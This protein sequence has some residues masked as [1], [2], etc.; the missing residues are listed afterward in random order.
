MCVSSEKRGG[1]K[2]EK[3]TFLGGPTVAS[4]R[5]MTRQI[6]N[7]SRESVLL[8]PP[9]W[10]LLT[11]SSA[12]HITVNCTCEKVKFVL[13][14]LSLISHNQWKTFLLE[15]YSI[16]LQP[17]KDCQS[18]K[19]SFRVPAA[20]SLPLRLSPVS[21]FVCV[22]IGGSTVMILPCKGKT[23]PWILRL[24]SCDV[25]GIPAVTLHWNAVI[26]LF[27]WALFPSACLICFR[28]S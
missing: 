18:W 10:E 7:Q 12:L 14:L 3:E 24:W 22:F 13:L 23:H 1:T 6:L 11:S 16:F 2:R 4:G 27:Q 26:H 17:H 15:S 21:S 8:L 5:F 20:P 9:S 28:F 19:S 25:H